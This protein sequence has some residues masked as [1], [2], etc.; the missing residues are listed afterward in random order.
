[1]KEKLPVRFYGL[2]TH[3]R[4]LGSD[5]NMPTANLDIE[6]SKG[7]ALGVYYS[8]VYIGE[9]AY[10]GITNL[11][12]KPTVNDSGSV[13]A[14]TFIYDFSG[15]LYGSSICVELLGFRRPE[16]KFES[17]ELLFRK[18]KEDIDAGKNWNA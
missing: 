6:D 18:I 15:D 3:G 5:F 11:G 1:M 7:L 13:N 17:V 10:R 12:K 14:E 16:E 8:K 4:H 9:K 2:V